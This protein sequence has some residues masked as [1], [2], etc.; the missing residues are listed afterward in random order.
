MSIASIPG[1]PHWTAERLHW[2]IGVMQTFAH[3][4]AQGWFFAREGL[5]TELFNRLRGQGYAYNAF[6]PP[7]RVL[8]YH[9][10]L[11]PGA[12]GGKSESSRRNFY[13]EKAALITPESVAEYHRTIRRRYLKTQSDDSATR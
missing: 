6:V 11:E 13:P 9:G 4:D 3:H 5:Q 12:R 8:V 10:V 2:L 1:R 7:L